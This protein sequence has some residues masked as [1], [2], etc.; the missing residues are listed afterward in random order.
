M[1]TGSSLLELYPLVSRAFG[2]IEIQYSI[3]TNVSN[4]SIGFFGAWEEFF[5]S[6]LLILIKYP[7]SFYFIFD[8]GFSSWEYGGY[9]ELD[10]VYG[11]LSKNIEKWV[12]RF[13]ACVCSKI[14]CILDSCPSCL[15][16]LLFKTVLLFIS[17][18]HSFSNAPQFTMGWTSCEFWLVFNLT[19][20]FWS[21]LIYHLSL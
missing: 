4:I 20:E 18:L 10:F 2:V 19:L 13:S 21:L 3:F 1:Y 15:Y 16:I 9:C 14:P 6:L 11:Y 8:L 5:S 17:N 12:S 7:Q